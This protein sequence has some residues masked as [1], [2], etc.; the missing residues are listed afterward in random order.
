MLRELAG[1]WPRWLTREDLA[2]RLGLAASG[3]T[4]SAYLSRLRS[5]GLIE[6]DGPKVRAAASLMGG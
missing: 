1:H 3:G 2:V 5:P 4:F 6:V